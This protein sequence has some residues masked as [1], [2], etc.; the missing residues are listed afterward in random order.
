VATVTRLTGDL[1]LAEDAVQD[2]CAE[3]VTRWPREGVPTHPQAWLVAVARHKALDRL[4]REGRR[5]DREAAAARRLAERGPPAPPGAIA[6][7]ELCLV[8]L[9][10]HPALAPEAQVALTLRAVGGLTTAEVAA[11][12]LV[13]EATMAKRLLR[14]RHKIR[15][16][17]IPFRLP[18]LDELPG[19]LAAVLRVVYLVFTE[20][21]MATVGDD[22]V[23]PDL[24]DTAVRLARALARLLPGEP[25]VTGL[26]ALLLLTDARRPARTD[27]HG[28]LVLLADQD[29]GRWDRALVAEGEALVEQ[30][31]R[32]GRPGPY[33]VHA[34]IAACHAAAPTA[35]D[36]DWPQ[37]A[38]LYAELARYEPT[39][40]VAANR[41]VAVAM[42]GSPED[43]LAMLDDLAGDG[44]MAGWAHLHVAR[45]DLLARL[46]RPD[47][48][49]AAYRR[50]LGL[51]PAPA[52]AR[53]LAR[54]I[55]DLT[56]Q[57]PP[58][59]MRGSSGATG[60]SDSARS[61]IPS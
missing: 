16:A 54:R 2:A 19:R 58:G 3:A 27:G 52:E 26:L 36:T 53:F 49:V 4:R 10:C 44:R 45:A 9:C 32:A 42:A 37:I 21:H 40:V 41:A 38:A 25:E 61:R 46:G 24:C 5:G 43:G 33:Q 11:A 50:A 17:G 47:E 29:R 22:L 55:A 8:L 35:E 1:G 56:G 30:A 6:D 57:P 48:A 51:D 59:G 28:D 15:A 34:A 31:L 12:F 18:P 7:D 60:A 39:P 13:P 20:G 14:A 23:R